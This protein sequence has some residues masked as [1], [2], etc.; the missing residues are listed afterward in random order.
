MCAA[1]G[2]KELVFVSSTRWYHGIK[3]YFFKNKFCFVLILIFKNYFCIYLF[4]EVRVV[5][6]QGRH[7]E[8]RGQ[9]AGISSL[10]PVCGF[11]ELNPLFERVRVS[12]GSTLRAAQQFHLFVKLRAMH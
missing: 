7:V 1:V 10:P 9:P 12:I 3:S 4:G 6:F 11:R 5:R 2:R 8:F